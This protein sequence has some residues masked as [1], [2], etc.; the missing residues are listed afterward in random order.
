MTLNDEECSADE[1]SLKNIIDLPTPYVL[2]PSERSKTPF[3]LTQYP[4]Q[5]GMVVPGRAGELRGLYGT[6]GSLV[7]NPD[8]SGYLARPNKPHWGVDIYAPIGTEVIAVC[9]GALS[10]HEEPDGLGLY[11]QL[12][13]A[14]Q[15]QWQFQYGHLGE[16]L[17]KAGPVKRGQVIG[18]V[19][20]S[21]N[22]DDNKI[23]EKIPPGLAFSAS[24]LHLQLKQL[25]PGTESR[26][27]NPLK[28]LGWML[29]SPSKPPKM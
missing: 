20:C 3:K 14:K 12:H 13:I 19:G 22:A 9:D 16:R 25:S 11:A 17:R 4:T 28:V 7:W 21:G 1:L 15:G 8:W 6:L 23:C 2:D 27:T 26:R 5:G 18:R 24:H 29:E 10:F